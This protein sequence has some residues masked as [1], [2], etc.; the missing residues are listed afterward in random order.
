MPPKAKDAAHL[1]A[2]ALYEERMRLIGE[3]ID[4]HQVYLHN[5]LY[6]LTRHWQDAEN[7]QQELWRHALLHLPTEK[8]TSLP[9]LRRKAWQLFIDFY[10]SRKR[11]GEVLSDEIAEHTMIAPMQEEAFTEAEEAQF[12]RSFWE[13]HP[14]IALDDAQRRVLWL[15]AR[16][17]YTYTEIETRTGIPSSTVCDW[18]AKSRRIFAEY[19]TQTT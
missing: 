10:R 19:L 5:Y 15:N 18:I 1:E 12:E 11:K 8:I 7:I 6:G 3:A 14:G 16:F 13:E 9:I 17:G 2:E 4:R